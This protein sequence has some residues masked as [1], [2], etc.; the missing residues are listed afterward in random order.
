MTVLRR[1]RTFFERD[2][3]QFYIE[4]VTPG[5][6]SVKALGLRR[7]NVV[8]TLNAVA[9]GIYDRLSKDNDELMHR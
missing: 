9:E 8:A 4:T 6:R 2:L 7:I 3:A 1:P 5:T